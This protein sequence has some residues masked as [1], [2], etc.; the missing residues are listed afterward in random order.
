MV[1][2]PSL[3]VERTFLVF[4]L[5]AYHYD[6]ARGNIVLKIHPKLAPIK[7]AIF[8]IVKKPAFE[9]IPKEVFDDLNR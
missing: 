6:E 1:C 4:M 2:E 3:G 9:K 5:D 7:A 8:P